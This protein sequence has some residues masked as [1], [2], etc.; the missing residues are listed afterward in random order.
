MFLG[1]VRGLN[2]EEIGFAV[3][4]TGIFQLFSVPFYSWL[5]KKIN[6]QWLLMAGLGG[7]VF[8]MYL[9]TPITHEWGWQELLFPQAIRGISQ[10]FA[11][12]P[13]VTLTLGGIPKERLKLA[14]GVFNLTRNLGG[15]SGIALCGSILNNRT[16]FHFSRM[17]E[18]M[19]SVPH[20]MNDFISRSALFFNRSGSDQTSE[21]LASTKLL[22]QLMLRE[23]Q[24]MAFSDT[25]LLISGL[26]FIAFLLVPAM[27]K[28]S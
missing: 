27:N 18:K 16:N 1:Q 5:S 17:G 2:A 26:L 8:S 7:F 10:Q 22:S 23:A 9:F 3:C 12:A 4:T 6:L 11:M 13:I 14:S 15:A 21:I 28:S 20:T 24:T 19:V 25:F